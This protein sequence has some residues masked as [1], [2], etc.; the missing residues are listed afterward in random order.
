M[1]NQLVQRFPLWAG[2]LRVAF[3]GRVQRETSWRQILP[4]V[5]LFKRQGS[6]L[7]ASHSIWAKRLPW[8]FVRTRRMSC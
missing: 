1:F 8:A 4:V 2:L 3:L 6:V 5:S 7:G